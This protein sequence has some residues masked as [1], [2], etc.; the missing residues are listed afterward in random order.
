[1]NR[2]RLFF[3]L[4]WY[5][6]YKKIFFKKNYRC[7]DEWALNKVSFSL[8]HWSCCMFQSM[9]Q[10]VIHHSRPTMC[11]PNTAMH[12]SPTKT[13]KCMSSCKPHTPLVCQT[14]HG[15]ALHHERSSACALV[16]GNARRAP[17]TL[18]TSAA[19]HHVAIPLWC[20]ARV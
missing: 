10:K 5:D 4:K 16:T 1:M 3:S 8:N 20:A 19:Q 2:R 14:R 13:A 17:T 11:R 18:A 7:L 9:L 15:H 6:S 12:M